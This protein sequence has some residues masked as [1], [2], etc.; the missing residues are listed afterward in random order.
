MKQASQP[1][2]KLKQTQSVLFFFASK[3]CGHLIIQ[4]SDLACTITSTGVAGAHHQPTVMSVI[5]ILEQSP[6]T[7]FECRGRLA[8]AGALGL[9]KSENAVEVD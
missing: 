2:Q 7:C 3:G 8:W 5:Q 9:I 4:R 6:I 1:N